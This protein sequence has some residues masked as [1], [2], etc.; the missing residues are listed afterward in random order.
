MLLLSLLLLL[1]LSQ[2][3]I[4][5]TLVIPLLTVMRVEPLLN[6]TIETLL[7]P[8]GVISIIPILSLLMHV[9]P[10]PILPTNSKVVAIMISKPRILKTL[11]LFQPLFRS[12]P[13]RPPPSIL[14]VL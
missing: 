10:V 5:V 14:P 4:E 8:V 7:L 1:L 6:L 11:I 12:S 3:H 2:I 13:L 9:T